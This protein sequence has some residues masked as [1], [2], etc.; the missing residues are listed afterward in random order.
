[1]S[2]RHALLGI[3]D[4]RG[5][6]ISGYDIKKAFNSTM[7]FY[8]NATYTQIYKTLNQMYEDGLLTMEVI[9][10]D[11]YPNKKVY[12]ITDAGK[13]EIKKWTGKPL[14]IQRV[15]NEMLVQITLADRLDNEQVVGML[16]EYIEKVK[17]KLATLKSEE[18]QSILKRARTEREGFFWGISLGKG[19]MTYERE[20]EWAEGVLEQFEKRFLA[21]TQ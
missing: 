7:Q 15:R 1:M 20:L 10:Q 18:V 6:P 8:W 16:K 11:T 21:S 3:I 17:D 5:L 2:L 4:T 19:V 14:E 12:Q 9:H 13:K